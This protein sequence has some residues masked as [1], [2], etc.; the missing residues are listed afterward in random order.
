MRVNLVL[1]G[2]KLFIVL[3]VIVAGHQLHQPRQLQPVHPAVAAG[4]RPRER[5]ARRRCI[6]VHLRAARRRPTASCGIIAGAVDR[7]LRLH[8]LRRRRDDGRGG[9]EPAARPAP[10]HHRL[11]GHL[12]DP[13]RR[14]HARHHRHGATTTRST[15]RRRWPRPS[16]RSAR[17]ATPRSISAGAVAGLTTVVMTLIIGAT[18]VMFAMSRDWLLP[19]GPGPHQPAAP[20]PRSGS[21]SSSA[22]SSPSSPR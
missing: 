14:R 3:F 5:P 13:L 4:A 1:V 8:R 12:H 17:T 21:R 7:L 20:A 19:G 18:R 6:Q 2:V 11:A 22:P 15:P 9:Q 10:R 16:P